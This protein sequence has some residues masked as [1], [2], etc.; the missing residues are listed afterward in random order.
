MFRNTRQNRNTEK[1]IKEWELEKGIKLVDTKGFPFSRNKTYSQKFSD[2]FF[3]M[4]AQ[5]CTVKCK[6]EKGLNFLNK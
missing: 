3:R 2:K 1:T 4:H 6:T 5:R